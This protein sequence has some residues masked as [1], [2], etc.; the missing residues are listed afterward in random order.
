MELNWAPKDLAGTTAWCIEFENP[1]DN[2]RTH[3]LG[4]RKLFGH[5]LTP[6]RPPG[7]TWDILGVSGFFRVG[8]YL[9][10]WTYV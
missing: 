3:F 2:L 7:L 5:L 8:I 6:R 9:G 10:V 1:V 4:I